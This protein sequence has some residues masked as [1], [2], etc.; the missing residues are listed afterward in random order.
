MSAQL[1]LSFILSRLASLYRETY[2]SLY[3]LAARA[4]PRSAQGDYYAL[5]GRYYYDL[6]G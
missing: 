5:W 2:D 6:A 1:K 3:S 4:H